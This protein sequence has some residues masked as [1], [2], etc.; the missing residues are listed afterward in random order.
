MVSGCHSTNAAFLLIDRS[1]KSVESFLPSRSKTWR[2]SRKHQSLAHTA[3]SS[4][5]SRSSTPTVDSSRLSRRGC[6]FLPASSSSACTA[7]SFR[8][9]RR[10]LLLFIDT[11]CRLISISL[12]RLSC[13]GSTVIVG[14]HCRLT[15]SFVS[16]LAVVAPSS[17]SDGPLLWKCDNIT[18]SCRH[19]VGL[20][21]ITTKPKWNQS[22][23]GLAR[24]LPRHHLLVFFL[25]PVE[26]APALFDWSS[27]PLNSMEL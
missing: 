12:S 16:K 7:D 22:Q 5:G 6:R 10:S 3:T 21:E 26:Y 18:C 24:C 1:A 17:L 20:L 13:L 14:S 19:C 8:T 15:S 2:R 11:H 27:S 23:N 9:S 25:L 4:R